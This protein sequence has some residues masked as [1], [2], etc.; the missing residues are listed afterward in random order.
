MQYNLSNSAREECKLLGFK[1]KLKE[2]APS[3][4]KD[5]VT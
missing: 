2:E 3:L 5:V 4:C 1:V